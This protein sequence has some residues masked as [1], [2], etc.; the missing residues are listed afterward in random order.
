MTAQRAHR[1]RRLL[2]AYSASAAITLGAINAFPDSER[3]R[4]LIAIERLNAAPPGQFD[5]REIVARRI[6]LTL[7]W[8]ES[9]GAGDDSWFSPN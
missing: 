9:T 1:M 6:V 2:Q 7:P 5:P 8:D 3:A 4:P